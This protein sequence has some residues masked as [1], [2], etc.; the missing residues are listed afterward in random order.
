MLRKTQKQEQRHV[1]IHVYTDRQTDTDRAAS[2]PNG[3]FVVTGNG[4]S[5]FWVTDRNPGLPTQRAEPVPPP[6]GHSAEEPDLNSLAGEDG[7]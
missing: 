3:I 7:N 1:Y 6:G 5:S 2:S 4:C